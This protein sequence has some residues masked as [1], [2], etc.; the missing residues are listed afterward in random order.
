MPEK[1]AEMVRDKVLAPKWQ[2]PVRDCPKAFKI[3]DAGAG[4]GLSVP[5]KK[6]NNKPEAP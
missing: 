1:M 3:L 5:I 2:D 6:I 4:D